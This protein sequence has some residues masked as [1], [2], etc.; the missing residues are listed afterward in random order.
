M[1][2]LIGLGYTLLQSKIGELEL[3]IPMCFMVAVIHVMLVGFGKIKDD[4]SYKF[5]ENEGIV[6]WL[7]LGLRL[8]L[9]L[10]FLWAVR[11]SAAESGRALK[12][13]LGRF[14]S[15]GTIY[16]LSYPVIFGLT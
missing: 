15:A 2:I 3:M 12:Q 5:H 16:F 9:Y 4:A 10:W 8:C 6:G 13:F 14:R 1:G 7:L 11:S